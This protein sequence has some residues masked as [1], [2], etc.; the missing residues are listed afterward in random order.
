MIPA[1]L[2]FHLRFLRQLFGDLP[3][4]AYLTLRHTVSRA[5]W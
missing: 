1:R 5:P 2:A 3:R 4:R